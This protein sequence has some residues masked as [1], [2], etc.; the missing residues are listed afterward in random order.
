M[1]GLLPATPNWN[2]ERMA[3]AAVASAIFFAMGLVFAAE[4][5]QA[6]AGFRLWSPLLFSVGLFA[7]AAGFLRFALIKVRPESHER[8]LAM[9]ARV[10]NVGL[11]F[12]ALA[13]AAGA[14]WV[15]LAIASQANT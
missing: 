2:Y 9:R 1:R 13:V 15:V 5:L 6:A 8:R 12:V 4:A 14:L 3:L 11:G 7:L 10:R